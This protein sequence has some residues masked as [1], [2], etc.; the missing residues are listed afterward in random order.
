MGNESQGSWLDLGERELAYTSIPIIHPTIL[1]YFYFKKNLD[2][3]RIVADS[4]QINLSM[5]I[6]GLQNQL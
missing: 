4:F 3:Y 6:H 1:F 5:L 2:P